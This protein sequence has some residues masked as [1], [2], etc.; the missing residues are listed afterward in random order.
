VYLFLAEPFRQNGKV[1]G[2]VYLTRSTNP[3]LVELHR[4]RR[5][6]VLVLCVALAIAG[7]MTLAL[8]LSI[9]RPLERLAR[10]ARRIAAGDAGVTL[11]SGGG[12]EI[13][14]LSQAFAAMTKQLEARQ[15]YI[16][17]FAAD[18]AH[19]FKSPLTS[20]RGAAELL[21]EGAADDPDARRRFLSNIALDAERLDRLV[22]RV[23]ELS[24]IEAGAA[25][26]S[27]VPLRELLE[28]VVERA[29]SPTQRV[30]LS[31]ESDVEFV[32][33]RAGDLES[34]F[35]NLIDNALRASPPTE[36]V[37]V[38][39]RGSQRNEEVEV[40]V[41]DRGHGIAEEIGAKVFERFFS[42]D[43]EGDGTGLGLA[44]VKSVVEAHQ[45]RVRFESEVGVGTVFEVRLPLGARPRRN[46]RSRSI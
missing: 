18:V 23:R 1:L 3:V 20:I 4:I 17:Q 26:R 19:E 12:G 36:D 30:V 10:A 25:P 14:E 15:S 44:I 16:S 9:S 43:A 45:G 42:T 2:A 8:S 21:A 31:Y 13:S 46:E 40:R 32:F 35:I 34:A 41:V 28:R 33:A 38:V 37:R 24:R 22:A 27:P 5:G 7:L 29:E 6:L 39:V 11:P